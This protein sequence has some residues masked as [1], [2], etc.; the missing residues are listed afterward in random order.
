MMIRALRV[1][2]ARDARA[3]A[4]YQSV[5]NV[6]PDIPNEPSGPKVITAIPGPKSQALS[7]E[8]NKAQ[9]TRTQH[10]FA[11]FANSR[12]NYVVDADGNTLLDVFCQISSLP[13]GIDHFVCLFS[14]GSPSSRL[15]RP[16]ARGGIQVNRVADCHYQ[17]SR[18]G[19]HAI[20]QLAR[21]SQRRSA[22]SG[23]QGPQPGVHRDVR[24]VR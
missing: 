6:A 12:G 14:S 11:D 22:V 24:L 10:F 5:P 19:H 3:F 18:A 4:S 2:A 1:V 20:R 17:P 21:R 23:A 16:R 15:Q 9:D 8:L 13:L 7:Q